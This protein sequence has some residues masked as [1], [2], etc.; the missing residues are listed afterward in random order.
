MH[1]PALSRYAD[2]LRELVLRELRARYKQSLLGPAWIV[3]A[4]LLLL[5]PLAVLF[6][7]LIPSPTGVPYTLFVYSGLLPWLFFSE[8]V[9]T[10]TESLVVN[11]PLIRRVSFARSVLP[12]AMVGTRAV[13]FSLVGLVTLPPAVV[14]SHTSVGPALLLLPGLLVL[15]ALFAAGISLTTSVLYVYFRD[16]RHVLHVLLTVWMYATPIV[17]APEMV[18]QPARRLLALNPLTTFVDST[19]SIILDSALPKP[20]DVMILAAW[21]AAG[22]LV[23][24]VTFR[25]LRRDIADVL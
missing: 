6:G 14:A 3:L 21:T 24:V 18:P 16:V 19:R 5:A 13:E 1:T 10:A 7:S 20:R 17:Y 12:L 8:S 22:L 15:L 2:L 9:R 25:A 4:P 23:G 11:A